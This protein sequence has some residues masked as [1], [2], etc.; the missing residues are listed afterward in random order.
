MQNQI[1][2]NSYVEFSDFVNYFSTY[3]S[4][5]NKDINGRNMIHLAALNEVW[6]P[7]HLGHNPL[8]PPCASPHFLII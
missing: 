2:L 7:S 1:S 8:P 3:F 4:V 6:F 5:D